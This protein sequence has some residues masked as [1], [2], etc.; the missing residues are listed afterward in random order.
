MSPEA[1]ENMVPALRPLMVKV[2]RDFFG[3]KM[4]ADD[5]AQEGLL[6][7]WR[8]CERLSAEQNMEA[9]AIKVAKNVCVEI[10]RRGNAP[11]VTLDVETG[12]HEAQ[13]SYDADA[14]IAAV[15]RLQEIDEAMARL[16]PRERELLMKKHMEGYTA[17]EIA[18]AT[19]ISKPSVK[20]MISMAR[21][22]LMKELQNILQT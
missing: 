9:L 3:N 11:T 4:D 2:G 17:D 19:G 15:E 10:Y 7:L 16:G 8:Y 12:S 14:G 6:R 5:V 1:F 18:Q 21:K 22:K 20:S 13:A